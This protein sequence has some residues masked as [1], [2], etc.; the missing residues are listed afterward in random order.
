MKK[1]HKFIILVGTFFV[2]ATVLSA[3]TNNNPN[4]G[5]IMKSG[6]IG[7]LAICLYIKIRNENK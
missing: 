4:M 2:I 1:H 7:C 5:E 6:M 3:I